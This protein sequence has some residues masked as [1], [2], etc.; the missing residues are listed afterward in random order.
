M[1]NST[2]SIFPSTK[3]RIII[4]LLLTATL[5][6]CKENRNKGIEAKPYTDSISEVSCDSYV[7][8]EYLNSVKGHREES[9]ITGNFTGLGIDT[10]YVVKEEIDSIYDIKFY[11]KSNNPNLPTIEMFGCVYATPMLVYEGD[12]DGDGKDE[13]G[14]LHT[15]LN[16][17]WRYYRIY[18][19][20]DSRKEWRFLYY[21]V[22]C[23]GRSLLDTPE[24]VRSSG[25]DIVEKGPEPGLIKI[26]YGTWGV[27]CELRDTVVRPTYTRISK[28]AW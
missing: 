20:D 12:V 18:N 22:G 10:I 13:W 19:Y 27:E 21:D 4:F 17:Q 9:L 1:F 25:V 15:W 14:Y 16:S 23:D 11:A 28:D 5:I 3:M 7:Q 2:I 24:Y 6:S 8:Q 26:N